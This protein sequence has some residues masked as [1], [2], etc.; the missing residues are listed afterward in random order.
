LAPLDSARHRLALRGGARQ[1]SHLVHDRRRQSW[2]AAGRRCAR[3]HHR[4]RA[5]R[6]DRPVRTVDIGPTLARLIG[7]V[8]TEPVLGRILP[9]VVH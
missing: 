7:V 3:P 8:P 6:Y 1:R 2:H 9:E 5:G 4:V